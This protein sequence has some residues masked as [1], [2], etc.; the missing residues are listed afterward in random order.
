[1]PFDTMKMK[2]KI[3]EMNESVDHIYKPYNMKKKNSH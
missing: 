2:T 1:M 3:K